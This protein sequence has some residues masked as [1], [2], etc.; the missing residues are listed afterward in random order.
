MDTTGKNIYGSVVMALY[1]VAEVV[2]VVSIVKVC[3]GKRSMEGGG[4]QYLPRS[5]VSVFYVSLCAFL[6]S[7]ILWCAIYMLFC[8]VEEQQDYF[9]DLTFVVERIGSSLFFTSYTVVLF[10]WAE[11][12]HKSYVSA[13]GFLP[14]L[15][16]AFI[17]LNAL[18]YTCVLIITLLCV[19]MEDSDVSDSIYY[20]INL[21]FESFVCISVSVAFTVYGLRL[22]SADKKKL[23]HERV[24][25]S[26][27][28][29]KKLLFCTLTFTT[30]FALRSIM[31]FC[32]SIFDQG[33]RL[34]IFATFAFVL[35]ELVSSMLQLFLANASMKA[36]E[37]LVS[38]VNW[39]YTVSDL[40]G[41]HGNY[42]KVP[43]AKRTINN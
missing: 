10:F 21:Y 42:E 15:K 33:M 20:S 12:T 4:A 16:W 13:T 17:A 18:L 22:V 31:F 35:P 25:S 23:P 41:S 1:A 5:K 32:W 14:T 37:Q 2:C 3:R 24:T 11:M 27:S 36:E 9:D 39:L 6:L 38:Y 26:T 28:S 7:R 19:F 34:V 30:C 43:I 29:W 8:N 40:G